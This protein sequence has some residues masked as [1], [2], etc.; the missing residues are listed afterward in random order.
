MQQMPLNWYRDRVL[1]LRPTANWTSYLLLSLF[2][3]FG[4]R[5]CPSTDMSRDRRS[6]GVLFGL[7][8][9]LGRIRVRVLVSWTR[10]RS[11]L[12]DS[13]VS[14]LCADSPRQSPLSP[15]SPQHN[16]NPA[17]KIWSHNNSTLVCLPMIYGAAFG[18]W[19]IY[20][21]GSARLGS[22]SGVIV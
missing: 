17:I 5:T 7:P 13:T 20:R 22:L 15:Q 8:R 9:W 6:A 10:S 14:R 21:L 2:F 16:N 12:A 18:F 3:F 11:R 1:Q 19:L 4:A